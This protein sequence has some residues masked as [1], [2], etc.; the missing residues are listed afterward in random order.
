MRFVRATQIDTRPRFDCDNCPSSI[1]LAPIDMRQALAN[2]K[3]V[4]EAHPSHSCGWD[5]R[6]LL[7][8]I[9]DVLESTT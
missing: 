2:C 7:A 9:S 3:D 6:G 8:E 4:L 1:W 5:F